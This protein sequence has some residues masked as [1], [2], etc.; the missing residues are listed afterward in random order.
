MDERG[1]YVPLDEQDRAL[2]DQGRIREG[3][4]ALEDAMRRRRPGPYQ[5]QA[6]IAALHAQAPSA[7]GRRL[8]RR[9]RSCTA[10][11]RGSAVAGR[12]AQPRRRGRV[13]GR[14][15]TR[16]SSCSRRCSTT[17]R[18]AGYQP[19]HAAHAELL[20]RCGDVDAAGRAYERAIELSANA[21]ERPSWSAAW[22]GSGADA[23]DR[24]AA[25]GR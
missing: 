7:G 9:S 10:R 14:A 1:R 15:G 3:L 6:A 2:W 24:S 4:R 23:R 20:R 13:R 8:A 22:S 19:L 12:R 11:W 16:G 18:L 17:P 21:V 5:M 25:R